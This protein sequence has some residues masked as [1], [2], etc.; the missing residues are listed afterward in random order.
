DGAE[1]VVVVPV[2]CSVS[3]KAVAAA[4]GAKRAEMCPPDRAE[5]VTGFVVGGISPFSQ[6]RS[7]PTVVDE[8]VVLF[9]RVY[10]SGGRRG[11][12]VGVSPNDLVAITGAVVAAV[13]A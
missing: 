10:V 4:F 11:V 7:L 2:T 6:R 12:D 13:T 5:R 8:T 1:S 3:M 9:D